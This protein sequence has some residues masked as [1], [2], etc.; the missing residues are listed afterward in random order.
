MTSIDILP[1][2]QELSKYFTSDAWQVVNSFIESLQEKLDQFK[3]P[4]TYQDSVFSGI[5]EFLLDFVSDYEEN[6]KITFSETLSLIQDI[7]SP[8]E[9]I[10]SMEFS[11]EEAKTQTEALALEKTKKKSIK[12][13]SISCPSCSWFNESDSIFCDNC[14]RKLDVSEKKSRSRFRISLPQEIISSPL[15]S[16][17]L[18]SYLIF[19]TGGMI[20]LSYSYS[21]LFEPDIVYIPD[22]FDKLVGI[23]TG[24]IIPAILAGLLLSVTI[25]WIYSKK[26]LIDR[27]EEH[28]VQLQK[29]F[30]FGLILTLIGIWSI[31]VYIPIRVT[32]DEM[33]ILILISTLICIIFPILIYRWNLSNKPFET[34]YFTFLKSLRMLESYNMNN[35]K[36]YSIFSIA[37]SFF[38]VTIGWSIVMPYSVFDITGIT[39]FGIPTWIFFA[40]SIVLLFYGIL[41]M[42]YYSWTSINRFIGLMQVS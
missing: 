32:R 8:S 26:Y 35:I 18:L 36:I 31:L 29:K 11:G 20:Y 24:M 6:A 16:G 13:T 41:L 27:Y 40:F 15:I 33:S 12:L 37:I 38:G 3:V 42:Y 14:G 30:S 21:F 25:N 28:L 1:R 2:I 17:F 23:S 19:V 39:V 5:Q 34:P 9:I 4:S 7:G 22:L 10:Q